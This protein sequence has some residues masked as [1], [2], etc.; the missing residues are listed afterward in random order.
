MQI[1]VLSKIKNTHPTVWIVEKHIS[2]KY[3]NQWHGRSRS[4]PL[5]INVVWKNGFTMYSFLSHSKSLYKYSIRIQPKLVA[6]FTHQLLIT[7]S[8]FLRNFSYVSCFQIYTNH[9][10]L[11]LAHR[12]HFREASSRTSSIT[13]DRPKIFSNSTKTIHLYIHTYTH[14][15]I[16][17]HACVP[18][19]AD[20]IHTGRCVNARIFPTSYANKI[21][22]FL[23][24][25]ALHFLY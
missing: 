22:S 7:K 24:P 11:H 21:R 17:P 10:L 6:T 23:P 18:I 14:A 1:L 13:A 9:S 5:K 2:I 20:A 25:R 8:S 19:A 15:H 12:Q 4:V 16:R 3:N